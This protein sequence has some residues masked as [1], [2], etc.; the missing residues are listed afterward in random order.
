MTTKKSYKIKNMIIKIQAVKAQK[1]KIKRIVHKIKK[2]QNE[3]Y[4]SKNTG[5][6]EENSEKPTFTQKDKNLGDSR[7]KEILKNKIEEMSPTKGRNHLS[8]IE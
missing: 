6:L 1:L 7:E 3:E 8:Q 4:K 5:K 2:Q